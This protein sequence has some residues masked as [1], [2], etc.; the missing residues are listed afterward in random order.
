MYILAEPNLLS[1]TAHS[2]SKKGVKKRD[3]DDVE[4]REIIADL[5]PH[6]RTDHVLPPNNDILSNAIK[7][8]LLSTPPSHMMAD[9]GANSRASAWVRGK[10]NGMYLKPRI[11]LPYYEE[12]K[13]TIIILVFYDLFS[14]RFSCL[15]LCFLG[16]KPL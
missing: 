13:V 5:L 1:H 11:F 15:V 14:F 9:E 7:R 8:G 6:V 10:N 12:A 4:L 3:L 16:N 2:V